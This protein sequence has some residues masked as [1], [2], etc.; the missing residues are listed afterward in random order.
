MFVV[1][2][3]SDILEFAAKQI[4]SQRAARQVFENHHK[5]VKHAI[6]ALAIIFI[7]NSLPHNG[8]PFPPK[9]PFLSLVQLLF[10]T[11]SING[12]RLAANERKM[13]R[14]WLRFLRSMGVDESREHKFLQLLKQPRKM[15]ANKLK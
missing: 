7:A 5:P 6:D 13:K 15:C 3:N 14:F 11:Y 1:G 9:A 12:A 4:F 8:L 2:I 10:M